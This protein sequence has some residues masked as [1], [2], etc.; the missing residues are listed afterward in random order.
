MK[1]I[2]EAIHHLEAG[3]ND[4]RESLKQWDLDSVNSRGAK[5]YKEKARRIVLQAQEIESLV[6][7]NVYPS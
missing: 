1:D 7:E 4:L 6:K 5:R 2:E 3:I